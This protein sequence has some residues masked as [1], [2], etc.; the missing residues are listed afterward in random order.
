MA[1][2]GKEWTVALAKFNSPSNFVGTSVEM[3]NQNV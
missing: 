2:E 1:M 3:K